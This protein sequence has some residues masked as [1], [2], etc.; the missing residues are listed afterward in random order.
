[1]IRSILF[2]GISASLCMFSLAQVKDMPTD[3]F[4]SFTRPACYKKCKFRF[5]KNIPQIIVRPQSELDKSV[6]SHLDPICGVTTLP[7]FIGDV[8]RTGE[9]IYVGQTSPFGGSLI[10]GTHPEMIP[11]SKWAPVGLIQSFTPTFFKADHLPGLFDTC[12][13]TPAD[14]NI[15]TVNL[16]KSFVTH[17]HPQ[18]NQLNYLRDGCWILP[19]KNY[20]A[21]DNS[22]NVRNYLGTDD[23]T[24]CVA[25]ITRVI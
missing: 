11:I 15:N 24:D 2:T 7:N 13:T 1:M 8:A 18:S 9:P 5:C 23:M 22:G 17:E 3:A 12:C 25:F 19:V 6:P 10:A 16:R 4:D 21:F 20:Q 14:N